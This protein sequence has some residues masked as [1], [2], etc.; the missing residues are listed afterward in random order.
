M[1]CIFTGP[2]WD[3]G[4]VRLLLGVGTVVMV[5]GLMMVSLCHE[6]YQFFL[7]QAIVTGVGFGFC[8]MPAS[9]IVPQWFSTHA[10]F[11]VGLATTGSS[12]GE[13]AAK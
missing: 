3:D 8:F 9:A 1:T 13:L 12:I 4:R 10:P 6:F 2:I 5:F 7:A 11:A